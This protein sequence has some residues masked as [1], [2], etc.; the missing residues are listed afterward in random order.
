M[1]QCSFANTVHDYFHDSHNKNKYGIKPPGFITNNQRDNLI[2][3][4]KLADASGVI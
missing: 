2:V 3:S 4:V 1:C